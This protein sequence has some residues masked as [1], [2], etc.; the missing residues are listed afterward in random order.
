MGKTYRGIDKK[1][2]QKLRQNRQK[3]F[4]RGIQIEPKERDGQ[5]RE[6]RN[7][8]GDGLYD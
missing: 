2:K 3:R 8:Y 6:G 7:L 1:F 5:T 4:K